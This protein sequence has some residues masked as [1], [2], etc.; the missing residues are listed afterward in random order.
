MTLG[1]GI[2]A[3]GLLLL[4]SGWRGRTLA[5][6]LAGELGMKERPETGASRV[7]DVPAFREV[8]T[9]AVSATTPVADFAP[10]GS[11]TGGAR[12]IVDQVAA[13]AAPYGTTVVSASRPG[14]TTTSGNT[15]DHSSN[16]ASRAARDIGVPGV[17][18]LTGPPP[19]ELDQAIVAVG[20]FFGKH[21]TGGRTI[22]DTFN[23]QGF[24]VQVIWRT[25]AYG[26]HLG[27]IHVGL[28]AL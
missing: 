16:D 17:N 25:P 28:R 27:H 8:E 6:T 18:A 11:A 14:S 13:A 3:A 5:E 4:F 24:R 23:W 20:Q 21:Y 19:A 2:L 26:G 1:F 15:S 10:M 7:F 12:A 22:V 9:P